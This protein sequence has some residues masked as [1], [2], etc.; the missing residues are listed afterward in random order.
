M[1]AGAGAEPSRESLAA[2]RLGTPRA[3]LLYA[4]SR[5]LLASLT[6]VI[7]SCSLFW[8]LRDW[9]E[10]GEIRQALLVQL[11]PVL[12]AS[13]IGASVASPFGEAEQVSA[14]SLPLIRAVH[15]AVLLLPALT[16]ATALAGAWRPLSPD[17]DLA[18]VVVRN[19]V[20][21]T[22]VTLLAARVADPRLSWAGPLAWT[23]LAL[24]GTQFLRL[25]DG[26]RYPLWQAPWWAWTARSEAAGSSWAIA[27]AL[28]LAGVIVTCRLGPRDVAGDVE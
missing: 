1:T 25:D 8:W 16:M 13:V 15:L 12:V 5:G 26:A 28:G 10:Q 18:L 27:L 24:I 17:A 19:I 22:A 6:G 3:L 23:A 9:G 21:L 7:A 14:R 2:L 20:G 4:R 11:I